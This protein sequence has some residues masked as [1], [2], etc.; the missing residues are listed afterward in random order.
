MIDEHIVC[1]YQATEGFSFDIC[2]KCRKFDFHI[3]TK[4]PAAHCRCQKTSAH[5]RGFEAAFLL[6][7]LGF[8]FHVVVDAKKD[9]GVRA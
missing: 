5:K 7:K 8:P 2:F 4:N 9:E 1:P 6:N 3:G